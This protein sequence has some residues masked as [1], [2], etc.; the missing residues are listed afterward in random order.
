V[1]VVGS[2]KV[3]LIEDNPGDARLIQSVLDGVGATDFAL[4]M[5][6]AFDMECVDRLSAG[7]KR[8]GEQDVDLILLDLSLPDSHG[9]D[10]FAKVHA[11][12]SQVPIIVL[13]G[14]ADADLA[15]EVV[16]RGAQDYLVKGEIDGSLL[17][18]SMRYAIERKRA[19]E[20]LRDGESRLHQQ[21]RL[22]AVGQLAGGIAHDFNNFLMTIMLYAN[23]IMRN[24][25]LPSD[26]RPVAQ[27]ILS[28]SRRASQLVS[29]VLDFSRRSV[30]DVQPVDLG[31]FIG[32][33][34]GI[35][36]K[37]L[38]ENIRLLVDVG[39]GEYVVNADP[40][41]V[42]QVVMNLAVNARDAMPEGGEL[43]I[44][45]FDVKVG[46]G[47]SRPVIEKLPSDLPS[48]EWVCLSVSDTGTGMTEEVRSH[49]FE[50]FFTTKGPKGTGLGLAQVY[51]IVK[52]HGG[53]IGVKS[54][55]GEGTVFQ[56]CL[57]A[58]KV[59]E[60]KGDAERVSMIPE[61]KGE[62]I[63]IVED[64]EEVREA[65]RRILESMGYRVLTAADGLEGVELYRSAEKVDLV[66][67]DMVMPVSG[68]R[69]L[70]QELRKVKPDVKIIVM[71]GYV[72]RDD[73]HELREEDVLEIVH[74]PLDIGILAEAIRRVLDAN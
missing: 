15:A 62:T 38:P 28:E 12:A 49:L 65:G 3:L 33:V 36:R 13:T 54:T 52:Q 53:Y 71:T 27:T 42:Q 44:G 20:A 22:A 23:L 64:E 66:I 21:E 70:V 37:T 56:I 24:E 30:I 35:L 1:E 26:L 5:F 6:S 57:P 69:A 25:D 68:G 11:Q 16:R 34:V 58:C 10:T 14:L 74:K 72:M 47:D 45:L 50:P 19:E 55:L 17:V 60:V 67:T 39:Q 59:G 48:G 63:L 9:L 18:R 40:T 43:R 29:Q 32:E 51:G 61:G 7:L 41:R 31:A 2:H 8:L 4:H 46:L 73:L